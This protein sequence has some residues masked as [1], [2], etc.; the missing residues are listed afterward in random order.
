MSTVYQVTGFN[1]N[2]LDSMGVAQR[3]IS[4]FN[5]IEGAERRRTELEAAGWTVEIKLPTVR[6]SPLDLE[7][8]DVFLDENGQAWTV[9][10]TLPVVNKAGS[11][12]TNV[13]ATSTDRGHDQRGSFSFGSKYVEVVSK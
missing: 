3:Q 10:E 1:H 12:N 9:V 13:T 2:N 4:R 7:Q 8:G 6:K 5:S 11:G